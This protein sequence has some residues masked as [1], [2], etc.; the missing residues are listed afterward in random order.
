[1]EEKKTEPNVTK[2]LMD[3]EDLSV[4]IGRK[5]S[6]IYQNINTIPHNQKGGKGTLYFHKNK[7]DKWIQSFDK[8][9]G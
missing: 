5:K 4:Y 6:W 1:M 9:G 2:L 8:P 3:I 7:I